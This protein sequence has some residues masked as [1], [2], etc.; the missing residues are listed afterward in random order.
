VRKSVPVPR[1]RPQVVREPREGTSGFF[2]RERFWN[3]PIDERNAKMQRVN[4]DLGLKAEWESICETMRA[5]REVL[6]PMSE[7]EKAEMFAPPAVRELSEVFA[8]G[9]VQTVNEA[10]APFQPTMGNAPDGGISL[11]L[12]KRGCGDRRS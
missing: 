9:K 7:A 3:L 1:P 5:P 2:F 6:P 10:R 8:T 4:R 12:D 11:D